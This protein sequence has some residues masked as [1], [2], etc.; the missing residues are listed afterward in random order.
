MDLYSQL[1]KPLQVTE[2]TVPAYDGT[3]EDEEI[4]A[5]LI[6]YLYSIWF[7]HPNVEQIVYWNL[8]DGYAFVSTEDPL[9]ISKS[10]GDMTLGE[11]KFR[12][13]LLRFDMS[14]KPAFTTLKNLIHNVW[15][16][17]GDFATDDSGTARFKGFYGDYD[18]T[19]TANGK[20]VTQ[21]VNLYSKG[22][23]DFEIV[24]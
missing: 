9:A 7:S 10:Q 8:I 22:K 1:G 14:E 13:G 18:V 24:L 15:H 11:N 21:K 17:E 12:G 4:Q 16:T 5:K 2:V 19:V 20:T 3:P 6:E 23:N